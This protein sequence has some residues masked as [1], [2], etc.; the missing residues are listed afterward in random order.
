MA[1]LVHQGDLLVHSGHHSWARDVE[2]VAKVQLETSRDWRLLNTGWHTRL[3]QLAILVA[4]HHRIVSIVSGHFAGLPLDIR[5]NTL[6][7]DVRA[8]SR[9]L[10]LHLL[11]LRL[12][13]H[14]AEG[15]LHLTL[16]LTLKVLDVLRHLSVLRHEVVLL[17]Q[18]RQVVVLQLIRCLT[19][20]IVL[21]LAEDGA[22]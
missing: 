1:E 19:G 20:Q 7:P 6:D 12:L 16:H 3:R 10:H 9:W 17:R 15:L 4:I 11:H 22:C 8:T 13:A 18:L 21:L 14:L 2:T 5:N